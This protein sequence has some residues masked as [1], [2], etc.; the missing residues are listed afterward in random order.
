MNEDQE[1]RWYDQDEIEVWTLAAPIGVAAPAPYGD[2]G[3]SESDTPVV[4]GH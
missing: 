4:I 1:P 3:N 2:D